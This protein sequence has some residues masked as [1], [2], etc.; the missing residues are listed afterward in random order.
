L[1]FPPAGLVLP[2][3]GEKLPDWTSRI[4]VQVFAEEGILI[5]EPS[6]PFT[7]AECTRSEFSASTPAALDSSP[8]RS[9]AIMFP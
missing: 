9:G 6:W 1:L 4:L 2:I 8:R 3:R 7:D 5:A